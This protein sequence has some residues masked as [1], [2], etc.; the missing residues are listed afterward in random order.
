MKIQSISILLLSLM[1]SVSCQEVHQQEVA[2]FDCKRYFE[3]IAASLV[4]DGATLQKTVVADGK[5]E[6]IDITKPDWKKELAPFLELDIN[7]PAFRGMYDV[8]TKPN[9]SSMVTEY[10]S[11]D[12]NHIVQTL[13]VMQTND[14]KV[15]TVQAVCSTRN[16]YHAS[17]DT[18]LFESTGSYRIKA[19]SN[20]TLGSRIA[21]D[22][23]GLILN[24]QR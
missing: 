23:K 12:K 22:I 3:S 24:N 14:G 19:Y 9:G 2:Y 16:P 8:Q 1:A 15:E 18:L 5:S 6:T 20:P 11:L 17:S 10:V 4:S 21:F 7:K 13:R